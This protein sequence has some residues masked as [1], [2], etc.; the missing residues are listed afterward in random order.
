MHTVYT[1]FYIIQ[2]KYSGKVKKK[3]IFA[4]IIYI[5]ELN[6]KF[7]NILIFFFYIIYTNIIL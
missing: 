7:K 1:Y 2:E 4:T 5:Q 6:Y 3:K